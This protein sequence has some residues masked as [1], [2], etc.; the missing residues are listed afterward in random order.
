MLQRPPLAILAAGAAA[1]LF[2]IGITAQSPAP[3]ANAGLTAIPGIKVGHHTME[4]RPTG[5]TVILTE[6]G[7]MASV[8]VRG[9]APGSRETALL[10]PNTHLQVVHALVLSGGSAFG[11]DAATGVV[12]YLEHREHGEARR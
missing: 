5:C 3:V 1:A 8:D 11:L 4:G 10:E 2:T 12:R 6:A 9:G 7:V